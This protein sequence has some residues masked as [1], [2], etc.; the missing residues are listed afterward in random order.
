MAKILH[1]LRT[2]LPVG[3]AA[4]LV[5]GVMLY[6]SLDI[7]LM[8]WDS[9][10]NWRTAIAISQGDF[11]S[12]WFHH[13]PVLFLMQA[14]LVGS[15]GPSPHSL[16]VL[17]M[18]CAVAAVVYLYL[19]LG[20]GW[21]SS[22]TEKA[23]LILIGGLSSILLFQVRGATIEPL[24]LFTS[25]VLIHVHLKKTKA[26][27]FA[28]KFSASWFLFGLLLFINYKGLILLPWLVLTDTQLCLPGERKRRMVQILVGICLPLVSLNGIHF[29]AGG[30]PW[31][32]LRVLHGMVL[33]RWGK[34]ER[35]LDALFYV[36]MLWHFEAWWWSLAGVLASLF[37]LFPARVQSSSLQRSLSFLVLYLMVAHSLMPKAPRAF[38]LTQQLLILLGYGQWILRIGHHK[39]RVVILA[40]LLGLQLPLVF[41]Y[42]LAVQAGG[43]QE[44]AHTILKHKVDTVYSTVGRNLEPFLYPQVAVVAL[45]DSE[46]LQ[47]LPSLTDTW[48]VADV[49]ADISDIPRPVLHGRTIVAMAQEPYYTPSHAFG[50]L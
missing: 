44:M 17:N 33:H 7:G 36:K 6:H 4:L 15:L 27:L 46:A 35:S 37:Y 3:L 21:I 43:T 47:T 16:I 13:S 48:I 14:F 5:S 45:I 32:E 1:A 23:L 50:S 42:H 24:A 30:D 10:D 40:G 25:I 18:V 34:M 11:H 2:M 28:T 19:F 29:L 9:V 41:H 22:R 8:D 26:S 12:F 31:G 38:V 20:S 39:I 49:Y